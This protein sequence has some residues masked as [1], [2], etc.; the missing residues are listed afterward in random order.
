MSKGFLTAVVSAGLLLGPIVPSHAAT[1]T[2]TTKKNTTARTRRRGS[3]ARRVGIGSA[4][5]AAIG[6]LAGGGRGAAIGGIAGAGA[7]AVHH[8]RQQRSR[9]R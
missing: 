5:G 7:G 3:A 6:A 9:N 8:N 1:Q 4:G 2:K